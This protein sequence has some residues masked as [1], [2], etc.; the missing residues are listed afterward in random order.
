M[1]FCF[2]MWLNIFSLRLRLIRSNKG[3]T[4]TLICLDPRSRLFLLFA[5]RPPLFSLRI[6]SKPSK[7]RSKHP[8]FINETT[9]PAARVSNASSKH[10]CSTYRIVLSEIRAVAYA[11]RPS[12]V[13][14]WMSPPFLPFTPA[15]LRVGSN[16][17]L[18][19][20]VPSRD[21]LYSLW[22]VYPFSIISL[23][24][25]CRYLGK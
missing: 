7:S 21:S 16:A 8:N 4:R 25:L 17:H 18:F 24:I 20:L 2:R 19:G 15:D 5:Q 12:S 23:R 14:C 9:R 6:P 1:A 11:S 13:D 3:L 22:G 10:L